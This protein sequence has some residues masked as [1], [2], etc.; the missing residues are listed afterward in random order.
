VL[1]DHNKSE[2]MEIKLKEEGSPSK[3]KPDINASSSSIVDKR[4]AEI[5]S[6]VFEMLAPIGA[7]SIDKETMQLH[8]VSL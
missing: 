4:K 1:Y 5:F 7:E 3:D 2:M 8:K 6:K